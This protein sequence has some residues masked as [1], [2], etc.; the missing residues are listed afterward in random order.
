MVSQNDVLLLGGGLLAL[1][2]FQKGRN[3]IKTVQYLPDI[4]QIETINLKQIEQAETVKQQLE[5]IR[6]QILEQTK[7]QGEQ[8]IQFIETNVEEAQR[9]GSL[10]SRRLAQWSELTR[11]YTRKNMRAAALRYAEIRA[12][13]EPAISKAQQEIQEFIS[14]GQLKVEE[15]RQEQSELEQIV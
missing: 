6:S 9:V 2:Y 8:K 12:K 14:R 3:D 10:L 4:P 11:E 15:I 1:M 5:N 13:E 7:A